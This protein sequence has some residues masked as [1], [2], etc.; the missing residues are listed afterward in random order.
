MV[1]ISPHHHPIKKSPH[2]N[3]HT[4]APLLGESPY[5]LSV[6]RKLC[7]YF[8]LFSTKKAMLSSYSDENIYNFP[9]IKNLIKFRQPIIMQ[10][11][12]EKILDKCHF[13]QISLTQQKNNLGGLLYIQMFLISKQSSISPSVRN[14][15]V[16]VPLIMWFPGIILYTYV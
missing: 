4:P 11:M 16:S 5:L 8:Q 15:H 13:F 7:I 9:A 6:L 14:F 1:K 3:F 2:Q 12:E 10:V